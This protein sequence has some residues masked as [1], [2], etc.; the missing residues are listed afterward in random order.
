MAVLVVAYD[1]PSWL[2]TKEGWGPFVGVALF[3]SAAA[4]LPGDGYAGTRLVDNHVA[5]ARRIRCSC[6]VEVPV[7]GLDEGRRRVTTI[8]VVKAVQRRQGAGGRDFEHG[9]A[10]ARA[11]GPPVDRRA[12]EVSVR[13]EHQS[14]RWLRSICALEAMEHGE[15]APR[16]KLEDRS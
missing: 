9:P 15:G 1:G 4:I 8:A 10:R 16:G 14:G 2:G 11:A 13:G 5:Q 3:A 7:G 12:I 6:A